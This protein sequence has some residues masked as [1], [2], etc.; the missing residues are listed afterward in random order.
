M[1]CH[2]LFRLTFELEISHDKNEKK[3]TFISNSI[4][5][6]VLT[7]KSSQ[8]ANVGFFFWFIEQISIKQIL[9]PA[10]K[11]VRIAIEYEMCLAR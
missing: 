11:C 1:F 2:Q 6:V 5:P 3:N 8:I 9:T 7:S 4:S 10:I